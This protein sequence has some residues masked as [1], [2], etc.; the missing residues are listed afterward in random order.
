MQSLSRFSSH[1]YFKKVR[2]CLRRFGYIISW[3]CILCALTEEV[4]EVGSPSMGKEQICIH[5]AEG[6]VHIPDHFGMWCERLDCETIWGGTG[7]FHTSTMSCP[8]AECMFIVGIHKLWHV[9]RL[10]CEDGKFMLVEGWS[11]D[12][13]TCKI[14][15]LTGCNL[16]DSW[17][18]CA[19]ITLWCFL[20]PLHGCVCVYSDMKQI[21]KK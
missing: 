7:C 13:L 5:T 8:H 12:V 2:D 20:C 6:M 15:S 21:F 18:V 16:W 4:S 11:S 9:L 10:G 19:C 3:K 14:K 1:S 17:R